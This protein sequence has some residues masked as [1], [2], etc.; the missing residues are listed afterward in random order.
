VIKSF[1]NLRNR[2]FFLTLVVCFSA[3]VLGGVE[4][5]AEHASLYEPY[6]R[7]LSNFVLD[8]GRVSYAE[9]KKERKDL[10]AF[11]KSLEGVSEGEY[12]ALTENQKVALWINAY[13][14]ITL[15]AIVNNYPIKSNFV[16]SLVYPKNSI[17]QIDEVW[18]KRNHMIAKR[19]V[20]LNDIEHKILREKFNYPEIH[21]ALVC[22][23]KS[24]PPLR[25]EPYFA[26]LLDEQFKAQGKAFVQS[27]R[28]FELDKGSKTVKISAIF[29]WF[30]NDFATKYSGNPKLKGYKA[31][32]SSVLAYLVQFLDE[33]TV[34]YLYK[35]KPNV[36]YLDYDWSLNDL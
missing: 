32:N 21:V 17:R 8:D 27:G 31:K 3:Y 2:K 25:N 13:N 24:C 15:Q 6:E 18:E 12:A 28:G 26:D 7:V 33:E 5:R 14:A 22:A 36:E 20:S 10:D 35:N 29:D 30:G 16:T 1:R 4:A 34:A 23:A 9:L 11:I 19:E